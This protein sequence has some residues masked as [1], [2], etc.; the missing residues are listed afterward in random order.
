MQ[1]FL[2]YSNFAQSAACLDRQR[3]GKQRVEC[4]QILSA[5]AVGGAWVKHPAVRM[6]RGHAAVLIQ[7]Y[8][9]IAAE[10]VKRG[11]T[12]N[13][14]L[15]TYPG[16]LLAQTDRPYWL[17][18]RPFHE[19]H[20]Q[21]LLLK[22]TDHYKKYFPNEAPVYGY[23]WPIDKNNTPNPILGPW[24]LADDESEVHALWNSVSSAKPRLPWPGG[25]PKF[26]LPPMPIFTQ[27]SAVEQLF[28][29]TLLSDLS[30]PPK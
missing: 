1:T 5:L 9:A 20:R 26:I 19:A 10:W 2:P 30:E 3:L 29:A 6:W 14:K 28:P 8:E 7:Y 16:W 13:M 4:K 17:G 15:D 21:T 23:V 18:L 22:N 11:Y 24:V 25:V 27:P 12:H